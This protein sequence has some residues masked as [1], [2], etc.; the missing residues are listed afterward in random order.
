MLV[1][2]TS[3][4][5]SRTFGPIDR[6]ECRGA[7]MQVPGAAEPI[8]RFHNGYWLHNEMRCWNVQCRSMLWIQF[9]G[10][11]GTVGPLLGPRTVVALRGPYAFAGRE[12]VAKL[13]THPERWIETASSKTWEVMR[14]LAAPPIPA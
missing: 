1:V 6:V 8:A 3:A 4:S 14:I 10:E 2:L 5:G 7:S 9:A 12:R 11:S 13:S